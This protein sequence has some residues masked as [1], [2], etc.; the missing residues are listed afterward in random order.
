[1]RRGRRAGTLA[2]KN[3][4]GTGDGQAAT[5]VY[6]ENTAATGYYTQEGEV[7]RLSFVTDGNK[8]IVSYELLGGYCDKLFLDGG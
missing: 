5:P 1:M 2:G 3:R 8:N 4:A 7:C 6:Q